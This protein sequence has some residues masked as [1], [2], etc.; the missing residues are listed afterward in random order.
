MTKSPEEH[1]NEELATI[2]AIP[3]D[4]HAHLNMPP[5]VAMQ[6]GKRVAALSVKYKSEL[7]E[8]E[9]DP[10]L[11]DSVEARAE[12]YAYSV[13]A[14]D[15]YQS[16]G[17]ALKEKYQEAK[18]KAYALRTKLLKSLEYL[19]RQDPNT[20]ERIAVI[21]SGK[22]DGDLHKDMLSCHKLCKEKEE[23]LAA[24]NFDM[25]LAQ[26]AVALWEEMAH[27][28]SEADINP[29]R[30]NEAKRICAKAWTYLHE[31]LD[32]IYAAG[33]YRFMDEPEVEELFY[34]DYIQELR[35]RSAKNN[36]AEEASVTP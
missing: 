11:L 32:E 6:E 30:V 26:Q 17:P 29:E 22:G 27:L 13:A 7:S 19:F 5:E 24:T 23:F 14:C 16:A 9:I 35:K 36:T 18:R 8:T 10:A 3:D 28:D 34:R 21:R 4:K 25:A 12:A 1:Y 31:A 15:I 33:R 20:L 2:M